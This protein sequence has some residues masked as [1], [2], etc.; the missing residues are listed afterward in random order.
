MSTV[1][2]VPVVA[3]NESFCV[4]TLGLQDKWRIEGNY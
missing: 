4:D 2:E 1:F 3:E